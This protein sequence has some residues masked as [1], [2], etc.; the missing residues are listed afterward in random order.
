MKS[1]CIAP[2]RLLLC[3][4]AGEEGANQDG[5]RK[6]VLDDNDTRRTRVTNN[7]SQRYLESSHHYHYHR[8]NK[9][10]HCSSITQIPPC[11]VLCS[12]RHIVHF[13]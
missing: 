9:P 8:S 2:F 1:C 3:S 13:A 4:E 7:R 5:K 12:L 6:E 11:L 10:V